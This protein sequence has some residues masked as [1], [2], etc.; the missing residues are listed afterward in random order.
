MYSVNPDIT[1]KEVRD[2]LI[3]TADKVG[4]DKADYWDGFDQ[5]RA[6][7]KVNAFKAVQAAQK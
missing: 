3:A 6:Y 7:G 5:Q 1:P 2:I 4:G